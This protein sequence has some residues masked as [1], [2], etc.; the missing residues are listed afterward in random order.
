MWHYCF[1]KN[2]WTCELCYNKKELHI[3]TKETKSGQYAVCKKKCGSKTVCTQKPVLNQ[4][5]GSK[6]KDGGDL[7]SD[8]GTELTRNIHRLVSSGEIEPPIAPLGGTN[9]PPATSEITNSTPMSSIPDL[10][11]STDNIKSTSHVPTSKPIRPPEVDDDAKSEASSTNTPDRP[12][13]KRKASS[14]GSG[15]VSNYRRMT[16]ADIAKM[17]TEEQFKL[18]E[19]KRERA[20]VK[21][22][23]NYAIS[24]FPSM[25]HQR[26]E[27]EAQR[28]E[29]EIENKRLKRAVEEWM[30]FASTSTTLSLET[31]QSEVDAA[32]QGIA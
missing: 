3:E 19:K 9:D 14:T 25:K 24:M 12:V 4:W 1:G 30:S 23:K 11:P 7:L 8:L 6:V 28:N 18:E 5:L 26:D 32:I 29:L 21:K 27:L 10:S 20:K 13:S 17:S 16:K 22:E 2:C 15:A 31:M